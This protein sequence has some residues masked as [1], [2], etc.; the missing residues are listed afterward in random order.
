MRLAV[1]VPFFRVLF[2]QVLDPTPPTKGRQLARSM[3]VLPDNS[4]IKPRQFGVMEREK[5]RTGT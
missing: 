5:N 1:N 2:F 4:R 3:A